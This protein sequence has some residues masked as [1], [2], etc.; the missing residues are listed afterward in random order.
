MVTLRWQGLAATDL[1][2]IKDLGHFFQAV[3]SG[4]IWEKVELDVRVVQ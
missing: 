2:Y 4:D 1:L 3:S